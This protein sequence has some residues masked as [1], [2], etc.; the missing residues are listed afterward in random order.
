MLVLFYKDRVAKR[1]IVL[2]FCCLKLEFCP[3]FCP[4]NARIFANKAPVFRPSFYKNEP[5]QRIGN[6]AIVSD[7]IP[8]HNILRDVIFETA[9]SA[10]LG[11]TKE[12]RHMLLAL[13]M[14]PSGDGQMGRMEP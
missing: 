7:R 9:A 1:L 8:R 4:S 5:V 3:S 14:S 11:P 2:N 10:D 6:T 13:A 12:E